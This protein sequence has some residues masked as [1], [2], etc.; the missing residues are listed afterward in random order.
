M[1]LWAGTENTRLKKH[2][3]IPAGPSSNQHRRRVKRD[4]PDVAGV[5]EKIRRVQPHSHPGSSQTQANSTV[6]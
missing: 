1:C 3:V 6:L 2:V 4:N 5:S